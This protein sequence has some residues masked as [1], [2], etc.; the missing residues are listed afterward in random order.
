MYL[1]CTNIEWEFILERSPWWGGFWERLVQ[2]LKRSLRKFLGK[3][4][5]TY[6]ELLTVIIEI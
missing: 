5:L 2:T 3:L 4:K 1:K 6:E